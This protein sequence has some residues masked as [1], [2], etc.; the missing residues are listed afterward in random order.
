MS[1]ESLLLE[2]LEITPE[3]ADEFLR[4]L[5]TNKG[6]LIRPNVECK[7]ITEPEEIREF[8]LKH[9]FKEE[10]IK[11]K[12]FVAEHYKKTNNN[13]YL[14]ESILKQFKSI[15]RNS[16]EDFLYKKAINF[17]KN[18]L[19]A[20]HLVYDEKGEKLLGYFT[21]ANKSLIISKENFEKMSRSQQKKFSQSGRIL[22]NGSL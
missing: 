15:E 4:I 11:Q 9:G 21:L 3:S 22:E 19:S 6:P 10:D 1:T 16:V 5:E 13:I 18:S 17:E 20:T 7:M 14:I 12:Y 8:L 2:Y